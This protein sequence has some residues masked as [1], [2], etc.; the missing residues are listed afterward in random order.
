MKLVANGIQDSDRDTLL[1]KAYLR[2][3]NNDEWI[4]KTFGRVACRLAKEFALILEDHISAQP[5]A[6]PK[7]DGPSVWQLAERFTQMLFDA[8]VM[9]CKISSARQKYQFTWCVGGD[10]MDPH[11]MEASR[12]DSDDVLLASF[13]GLLVRGDGSDSRVLVRAQVEVTRKG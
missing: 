8:L 1:R 11:W 9:K 3:L 12:E 7:E 13:P 10:T 2:R 4:Q 5:G 6:I